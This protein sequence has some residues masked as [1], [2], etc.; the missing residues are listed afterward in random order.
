[1]WGESKLIEHPL[2]HILVP[3]APRCL[4]SMALVETSHNT[5]SVERHRRHRC[6]Y[7]SNS[8][9]SCLCVP[10]ECSVDFQCCSSEATCALDARPLPPAWQTTNHARTPFAPPTLLLQQ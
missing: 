2:Q 8:T 10:E 1:M 5:L 4:H 7:H 6:P 3:R 9:A